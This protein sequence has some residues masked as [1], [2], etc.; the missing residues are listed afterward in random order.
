MPQVAARRRCNPCALAVHSSEHKQKS[1]PPQSGT[2]SKRRGCCVKITHLHVSERTR[3][4]HVLDPIKLLH[5]SAAVALCRSVNFSLEQCSVPVE[6]VVGISCSISCSI[7]C[8]LVAVLVVVLAVVWVVVWVVV[9]VASAQPPS[10]S[11]QQLCQTRN[12]NQRSH[13]ICDLAPFPPQHQPPPQKK[14][15]KKQFF[16]IP[17]PHTR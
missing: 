13:P 17:R 10:E 8:S 7:R 16:I 9:L 15:T 11:T 5:L 2:I 3:T 1:D 6:L 12:K 4:R 14:K